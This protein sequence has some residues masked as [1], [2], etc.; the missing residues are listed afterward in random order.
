[1]RQ[2]D[3]V[4]VEGLNVLQTASGRAAGDR[5]RSFVSDFFDFSIYVDAEEARHRAVVRRAVPKRCGRR[6]SAIRTRT[7]IAS[8]RLSDE[9]AIEF[10]H[11]IWREINGRNLRENI[12]PTRERARLVLEK[13]PDHS[14]R[15]VRLRRL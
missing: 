4:I 12:L 15:S 10:A 7:S 6:C 13:G 1:M 3:I 2:P 11:G 5:R 8:R 14:V 9:E